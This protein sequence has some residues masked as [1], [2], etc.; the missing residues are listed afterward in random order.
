ML[1]S[2]SFGLVPWK[3]SIWPMDLFCLC[4]HTSLTIIY[5]FLEAMSTLWILRKFNDDILIIVKARPGEV[6]YT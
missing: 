5:F 2:L 1:T 3:N 6:S 4:L